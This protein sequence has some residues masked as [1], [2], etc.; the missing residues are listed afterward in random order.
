MMADEVDFVEEDDVDESGSFCQLLLANGVVGLEPAMEKQSFIFPKDERSPTILCFGRDEVEEQGQALV[1]HQNQQA[2]AACTPPSASLPPPSC[3]K[4]TN[5]NALPKP[6][7]KRGRS[8][9][10][11]LV[12]STDDVPI[13]KTSKKSKIQSPPPSNALPKGRREKLGERILTLQQLV[14]PFGKT[15]TASVLHEAMGYIKFLHE[16]VQVLCSPYLHQPSTPTHLS[17]VGENGGQEGSGMDLRSRGLCLVPMA[18]TF[19]L[20]SRNNGADLWSPS[21][22]TSFSPSTKEQERNEPASMSKL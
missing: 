19:H 7:R 17:E 14:S 1:F 4:S 11:S 12:T 5:F 15:D 21:M 18:C 22:A 13:P 20:E 3:T 16:Q 2:T 10:E 6:R 9:Q 8:S